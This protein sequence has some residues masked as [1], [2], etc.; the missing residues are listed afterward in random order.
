MMPESCNLP[1]CWAVL[2]CARSRGNMEGAVPDGELLEHIS[3][4]TNVTEEAMH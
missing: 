1:I 2:H 4:A 3:T